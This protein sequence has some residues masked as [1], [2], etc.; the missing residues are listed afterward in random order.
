MAGR[1]A[2]GFLV[3]AG[4]AGATA[5]LAQ[6]RTL[7]SLNVQT[8]IERDSNPNMS[9]TDPRGTTWFRVL[10][11][12]TT[13]YVYGNEEFDLEA[14]LTVEKSSNT[15]V[16]KDRVDPRLRGVWK[17]ADAVDT[18]QLALLVDR[19]A[20][21]AVDVREH[22]PVGVDGART[23][24][25]IAGSWT[26][27]LSARSRAG[28]DLNQEWDQ[29]TDVQTPDSR[30]TVGAARFTW[31]QDERRSWYAAVN[32]QYYRPEPRTDAAQAGSG[33]TS[34]MAAGALLG[35]TQSL[36]EALRL[37]ASAGPMHFNHPSKDGWQ[38][39]LSAE[40][41]AQRWSGGIDLA[42]TPSVNYTVGGLVESREGRAHLR[43]ELGP[44]SSLNLQ[45]AY[46]LQSDPESTNTFASVA[47][48]HQWTPGWQVS[49]R[50]SVN[51][52]QGLEGTARSNRI[53]L[54]LTYSASDL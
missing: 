7:Y 38:G 9:V 29:Y 30:L 6:S 33:R 46:S 52:Q 24:Y 20:L 4:A 23:L 47:W 19:R 32:G 11:N 44:R 21:R 25:S 31:Q 41:T 18:A 15:D 1:I 27:E 54:V 35:I 3:V 48:V 34:S 12:L 5:A 42:R 22:V 16:A 45:A 26:R 10:P 53:A 14:G 17:H 37:D 28:V 51:R 49:V 39:R 36:S 50:G 13:G 2:R 8:E 40:Y 43:Y